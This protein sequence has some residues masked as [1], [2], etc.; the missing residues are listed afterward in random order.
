MARNFKIINFTQHL[1]F[2]T[3]FMCVLFVAMPHFT[4]RDRIRRHETDDSERFSL[5]Q[6]KAPCPARIF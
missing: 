3:R 2:R 6:K 5:L 4:E 1:I